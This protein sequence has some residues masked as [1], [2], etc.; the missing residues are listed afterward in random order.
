[1]SVGLL[2]GNKQT[3]IKNGNINQKGYK[4]LH[5][6]KE[7]AHFHNSVHILE[8]VLDEYRPD[9]FSMCEANVITNKIN[10]SDHFH[11][12]KIETTKMSK[13]T[14]CSRT[15]ILIRDTIK[16]KRR[17]D[18]EDEITSNIWV[19]IE[20]DKQSFLLMSDYRQ[21]HLPKNMDLKILAQ[22]KI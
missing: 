5:W 18:L 2:I 15:A 6:N 21:W 17:Y 8:G 9:I 3:K 16:Y 11:N 10:Y 19:E 12:Y 22:T 1:M 20:T 13:I 4:L 7:R 14:G